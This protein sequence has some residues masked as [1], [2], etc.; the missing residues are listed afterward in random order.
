MIRDHYEFE[1]YRLKMYSTRRDFR[2]YCVRV[3]IAYYTQLHVKHYDIVCV[4]ALRTTPSRTV[5]RYDILLFLH[6]HPLPI[7]NC[8][9]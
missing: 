4:C 5:K 1:T 8:S 7:T 9:D 3:C 2:K 6:L